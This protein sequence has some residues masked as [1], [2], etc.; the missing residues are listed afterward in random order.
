MFFSLMLGVFSKKFA[1]EIDPRIEQIAELLPNANC[2]ACGY[3]GCK[4]YAKA[5][6]E[7]NVPC[8][9]CPA[10]SEENAKK[11][12]EILGVEVELGER[13]VAVVRCGGTDDQAKIRF[14][15]L[16]VEDC[17]SAQLFQAGSGAKA[18]PYGCLGLGSCVRA[19]PFNA[20]VIY[21]GVA[22][23]NTD[24]CTGCGK[25][26]EACPRGIIELVPKSAS[27]VVLCMSQLKGAQT[28]KVCAVG[29]IG[30]GICA[31]RSKEDAIVMEGN[32]PKV[33]YSAPEE[34][35]ASADICPQ[36]TILDLKKY[37]QPILWLAQGREELKRKKEEKKKKQSEKKKAEKSSEGEAG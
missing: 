10:V 3:A 15:Y 36:F 16:G 32:L 25:C 34:N 27:R 1:V 14:N 31:K 19:C 6:V 21:K 11:I 23:V 5:M 29:C 33:D 24:K 22:V 17:R 12:A 7:Q 13:K 18:C 8:D 26:V 20:I 35:F 2:G 37:P 30:C 9:L 28:K 4:D